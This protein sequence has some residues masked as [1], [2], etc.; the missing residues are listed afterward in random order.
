[1]NLSRQM[2]NSRTW[3]NAEIPSEIGRAEDGVKE[4]IVNSKESVVKNVKIVGNSVSNHVEKGTTV[5]R[6]RAKQF[7]NK[8]EEIRTNVEDKIWVGRLLKYSELPEWMKDNEF[9]TALPRPEVRNAY[10]NF[11]KFDY[12]LLQEL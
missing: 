12:K 7:G 1:M 4:A 5:V 6:H 10:V 11:N 9:I 8:F 3:L 2:S